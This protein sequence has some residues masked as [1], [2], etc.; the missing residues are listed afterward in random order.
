MENKQQQQ[1]QTNKEQ[2][3]LLTTQDYN[4]C[5]TIHL[6]HDKGVNPLHPNMSIH[7]LHSILYIDI[8]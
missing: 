4:S 8:F 2:T 3:P 1:K 7:I 6:Q 5:T